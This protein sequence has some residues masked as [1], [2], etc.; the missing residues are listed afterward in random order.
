[1]NTP[2][3]EEI[4]QVKR[5]REDFAKQEPNTFQ[6]K[7]KDIPM[8]ALIKVSGQEGVWKVDYA[9]TEQEAEC[10][11]HKLFG[12]DYLI[13]FSHPDTLWE[14]VSCPTL[15]QQIMSG[16][17]GK[18]RV[19][20]KDFYKVATTVVN[21]N[22]AIVH[23]ELLEPTVGV[24]EHYGIDEEVFREVQRIMT[25]NPVYVTGD[26]GEEERE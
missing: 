12:F 6:M 7:W 25:E 20:E 14:V 10:S 21:P 15:R 4:E 22:E 23:R 3:V 5:I 8:G 17:L 16:Y 1:M 24:L 18:K 19:W 11:L 13:P 2:T 26:W 9:Q